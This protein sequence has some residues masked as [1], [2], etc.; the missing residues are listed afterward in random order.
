MHTQYVDLQPLFMNAAQCGMQCRVAIFPLLYLVQTLLA[1][2][3]T[4]PAYVVGSLQIPNA[5]CIIWS[6]VNY[7][8]CTLVGPILIATECT[9]HLHCWSNVDSVYKLVGLLI[10]Y[11]H[12]IHTSYMLRPSPVLNAHLIFH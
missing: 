12:T 9:M 8:D 4:N 10:K 11:A 6:N 3:R 2:L 7:N 5:H 1:F